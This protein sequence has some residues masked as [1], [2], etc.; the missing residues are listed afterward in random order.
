MKTFNVIIAGVG[1]QGILLTGKVLADAALMSGYDV[2][3]SE[4]HGM[5]QRGGSVVCHL[6]FGDRVFS[7]VIAEGECDLIIGFEPLETARWLHYLV[8]GGSVV[9]NTRKIATLPVSAGM[10][11][12][13]GDIDK[14]IRS[15]AGRT[16]PV[17]ATEVAVGAGEKKAVN[18]VLL[19]AALGF[20][21]LEEK[22]I[23]ESMKKNIP[24]RF[25]N[26]NKKAFLAGKSS[27]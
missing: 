23:I 15:Y 1:G 12:Y 20:F 3:Q 16:L 17:N 26:I 21:P 27:K 14:I 5:A 9:Y 18:L 2:K 7:P 4:V 19:G 24:S 10:E 6:R 13:P 25:Y 8:E 22:K 11:N